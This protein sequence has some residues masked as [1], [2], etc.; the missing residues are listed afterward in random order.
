MS[1]NP[2]FEPTITPPNKETQFNR[3]VEEFDID[4]DDLKNKAILDI[5]AGSNPIFIS[6]CLE[7][8]LTKDSYAVDQ[9]KFFSE[10]DCYTEEG[11][12][13]YP[14]EKATLSNT[15]SHYIQ[16]KA[17]ELPF[18]PGAFDLI[19]MR[20]MIRPETDLD[21]VFEQIKIVLRPKGEF[22]IFPVFRNSEERKRLDAVLSKLD[23]DKFEY[24]WKEI[25][26]YEAGGKTYYRDLLVIRKK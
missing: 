3:Y 18:K 1:Y 13:M 7:R 14:K 23:S 11:K 5:G 12:K 25:N 9:E 8:G 16:A 15:K 4:V 10:Y 21:K 19:L 22:K 26:S 2:E 17:E 24:E 6:Q 20:S